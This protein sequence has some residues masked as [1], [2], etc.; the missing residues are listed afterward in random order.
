MSKNNRRSMRLQGY[1]YSLEGAYFITICT[2]NRENL[3]GHITDN[4]M[5]LN[6]LGEI[7][8]NAWFETA[9]LRPNVELEEFQ[10]MPNHLHGIILVRKQIKNPNEK[11]D[12]NT[13]L[14]SP[15]QTI[16]AMMRGFKSS[17]TSKIN[18][19]R[20]TPGEMI[21]QRNFYDHIIRNGE[22]FVRIADYIRNNVYLWKED[23]F[24]N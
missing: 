7:T 8:Y 12:L 3:F 24:Y 15:S 23:R 5:V 17:V 6:N 18:T 11:A 10:V 1:D 13:F 21:W 9:K 16:G 20:N 19:I 14:R 2:K 22:S 4:Q